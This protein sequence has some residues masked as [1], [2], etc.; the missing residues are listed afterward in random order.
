[1]REPGLRSSV[2]RF[3]RSSRLIASARVQDSIQSY[4]LPQV[5]SLV[6]PF[7]FKRAATW[8]CC[9]ADRSRSLQLASMQSPRL[10]SQLGE[11]HSPPG[12]ST[13]DL[14]TSPFAPSV[15]L[16]LAPLSNSIHFQLGYLGHGPASLEGEVQVKWAAGPDAQQQRPAFAKLEVVF[17][18]IERSPGCES[19][20]ELAEHK[21]ILWGLG[22]AG[23]SSDVD[24][25]GDADTTFW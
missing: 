19:G 3:I 1:M 8:S 4:P 20:I 9:G 22:A 7:S 5:S 11:L 2:S 18:G 21:A 13:T 16:N 10:S 12:Y 14:A 17:R 25:Q 24:Q 23:S 15:L 6:T